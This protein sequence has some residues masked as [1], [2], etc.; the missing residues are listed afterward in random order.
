MP[1]LRKCAYNSLVSGGDIP[2]IVLVGALGG[3]SYEAPRES[4]R[5]PVWTHP[6]RSGILAAMLKCSRL[7][8]CCKRCGLG[9]SVLLGLGWAASLTMSVHASYGRLLVVVGS[10]GIGFSVWKSPI[11]TRL[12]LGGP[13]PIRWL[14]SGG[15]KR[16][17][18]PDPSAR[19]FI[20]FTAFIPFWCLLPLAVIPTVILWRRDRAFPLGYCQSC[21]YDLTGNTTGVCSE[22]GAAVDS[23]VANSDR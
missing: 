15:P 3:R 19:R 11:E 7:R 1:T 21:G 10:G 5:R 18:V 20:A 14:P 4:S 16:W 8:R 6:A 12:R 13:E 23:G 22:C 17:G 9:V 2:S